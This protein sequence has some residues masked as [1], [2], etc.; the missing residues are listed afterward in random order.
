MKD[1]G[2][3]WVG[4]IPD[5]WDMRRGKYLFEES[6][7]KG[8]SDLTLLSPTQAFGVVPQDQLEGVVRVKV[9]TDFTTFKTVRPD[10]FIISLRSFQGGFE[11]SHISG[12]CS[13]AY[14]VFHALSDEVWPAYYARL[15]KC[16]AFIEKMDNITRGIREGKNI[17]YVDFSNTFLPLPS[18]AEQRRIADYL[19]ERCAAIDE[20]RRTIEDEIEALRRLRK[21]TIHRAVTR[22]LDEGAPMRN[23][24]VE[25]IGEIPD[26]WIVSRLGYECYIRARLGWRGLKADEYVDEGFAFISAFNVQNGK[27]VWEPLHF[28]TEERYDESPEIKIAV[29]DVLLV[30]DGA[31]VGKSAR[32]DALPMG[33]TAPNSSIGVLTPFER[34]EYRYLH[35]YLQSKA[36]DTFVSLLYNGMGVP[37][38]TQEITRSIK[39]P[40]PPLS[41]QQRIADYLDERCAAIDSVI[42]TRTR[43]LERLDDYRRAL[44]FAYVTGKKEVP[45]HE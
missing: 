27:L 3:D 37:H 7:K 28:I 21:A 42:D 29:G 41:E 40:L 16:N 32:V 36:F 1:S 38:L 45:S 4:S 20:V 25:W 44:I 17:G 6:S 43:Q 19:D 18:M 12:V 22:G 8:G 33:G 5:G 30:K 35:Y 31:G 23:S 14:T 11:W 34:L 2:A 15:F 13:P 9:D 39:L 10:D 24:G 26:A